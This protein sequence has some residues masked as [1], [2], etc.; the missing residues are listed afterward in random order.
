MK[1]VIEKNRLFSFVFIVSILFDAYCFT[2]IGNR[3][4]TVFYPLSA[5]F[6]FFALARPS[7]MV[8]RITKNPFT[9]L[10][11]IYMPLN[12][13]LVGGETPT[14]AV[15]MYLWLLF[16][17]SGRTSTKVQ[18]ES[19]ILVFRKVMNIMAVY[20]IYQVAAYYFNLPFANISIPGHMAIG[21]NW[22][23]T[24]N[25]AGLTLRRA[26]AIFRE[27]SFFSQFLAVN[28]LCYIEKYIEDRNSIKKD[29]TLIWICINLM[30]LVVSF[31]GTG[32]LMLGG[33]GIIL[34]IVINK[35]MLWNFVNR[36]AVL[37]LIVATG[38]L[39]ILLIPNQLSSY[40]FGRLSELDPTNVESIS[41][42]IRFVKPYVSTAEILNEHPWFGIGLGNT[43]NLQ[44][45]SV[46]NLGNALAV[47]LPRSFAELGVIGGII[48]ILFMI[49]LVNKNNF[50]T[51]YFKA[52]LISTF[53]MT[54]MHGTWTSEVYWLFLSL[55]NFRVIE[56][57]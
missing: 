45:S 22:G 32:I 56:G 28:M 52:V 9:L 17:C 23:N 2:T 40:L 15:S 29:H 16:I 51:P 53:L 39:W 31:S 35:S 46:G 55:L 25:I 18:F 1:L 54:F 8:G 21:Y 27:P 50:S 6:L 38:V 7:G 57:E 10:M 24:I 14:I 47:A 20:G 26:N 12:Y 36:H 30:A 41:A 33:G 3:N 19:I 42:Y 43:Y 4:I 44:L 11:L 34:L 49:K 5:I 48:Y 13:W 37:V